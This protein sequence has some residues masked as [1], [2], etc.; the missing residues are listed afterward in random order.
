MIVYLQLLLSMMIT[1]FIMLFL[2]II[3]GALSIEVIE[4]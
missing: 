4:P 1:V 2:F 3:I